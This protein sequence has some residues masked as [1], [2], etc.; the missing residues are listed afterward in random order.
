[1]ETIFFKEIN[2]FLNSL[3]A[4]IA[5]GIF[6]IGTGLILWVFPDTNVLDYGYATL[7]PVFS[8]G[9]YVFL[10]LIPAITMRSFA[11]ERKSGT[12]E[13]LYTL[14]FRSWEIICG[15]YFAS[16]FLVLFSLLPTLIYY[17]SI[18]QLGSPVGN[19]DSSG[20]LGS[21]IGLFFLGGVFAAIGVFCSA[22]TQNQIV[23]FILAAFLS[24][25]FYQGFE[26]IAAIN[27]WGKWSFYLEQLGISFHYASISK[28][29]LDFKD[30]AY[31]IGLIVILQ[32][33]TY[34]VL[35]NKK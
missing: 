5:I 22:L 35:E 17:Y 18:Y 24:F 21:Y 19:L 28:G 23:S 9:P 30:F 29:V 2:D 25:V 26:A 34:V 11:D 13:L 27:V 6:L 16:L 4:Y 31:F 8:F 3:V 1:M 32:V 20:I 12:L 15:K 10:F 7:E 33:A 14:P